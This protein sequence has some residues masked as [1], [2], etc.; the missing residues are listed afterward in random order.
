MWRRVYHQK[1]KLLSKSPWQPYKNSST[2]QSTRGTQPSFSKV[3]ERSAVLRCA[4]PCCAL[5][6]CSVLYYAMLCCVVLCY[7]MLRLLWYTV[8]CYAMLCCAVL[9]CSILCCAVQYYAM[10]CYAIDSS[11]YLSYLS[12]HDRHIFEAPSS[13]FNI[14]S[15]AFCIYGEPYGSDVKINFLCEFVKIKWWKFRKDWL[16]M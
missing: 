7:A 2:E 1:K 9:L 5:M 10:L 8:L 15:Y 12:H 4:V 16:I 14:A 13:F 3:W 11:A 6:Y